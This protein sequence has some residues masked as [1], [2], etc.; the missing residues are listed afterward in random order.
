MEGIEK[1]KL[2]TKKKSA[3]WR[4]MPDFNENKQEPFNGIAGVRRNN[5]GG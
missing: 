5:I 4:R 1:L 2:N 3:H